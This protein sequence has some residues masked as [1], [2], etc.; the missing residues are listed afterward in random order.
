MCPKEI[1][2][3]ELKS[4]YKEKK[5]KQEKKHCS[6]QV[7][8]QFTERAAGSNTHQWSQ[9]RVG[10]DVAVVG[11]GEGVTVN[12]KLGGEEKHGWEH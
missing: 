1:N 12:A 8:S 2:T 11:D 9:V 7:Q 4:L 5:K 6:N 3:F 10:E